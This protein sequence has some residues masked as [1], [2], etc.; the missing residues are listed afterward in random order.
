VEIAVLLGSVNTLLC[1]VTPAKTERRCYTPGMM[2][3][4]S[5]WTIL[6][7]LCLSGCR[8]ATV[9][10]QDDS[11]A[12]SDSAGGTGGGDSRD[13]RDSTDS[14]R[15]D[16]PEDSP[17]P[18]IDL[19]GATE[20]WDGVDNDCD[21]TSDGD[22]SY[23]GT[24]ATQAQAVYEGS[25]Y[26]FS[27]NCPATLN[28][29]GSAVQFTLT[30]TPDPA[31]AMAQLLLGA[32]LTLSGDPSVAE[33]RWEGQAELASANLQGTVQWDT[34]ADTSLLWSGFSSVRLQGSLNAF[35]LRWV[36]DGTLNR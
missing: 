13:S 26:S 7:W 29:S 6:F 21:G 16:S 5:R 32:L 18:E 4:L 33:D 30:C 8:P 31:D 1:G 36:A 25:A 12:G 2:R 14:G 9:K 22:G 23:T 15:R 17:D 11:G 10:L 3:L 34:N 27:L 28:R 35:S 24:C 19:A 20:V